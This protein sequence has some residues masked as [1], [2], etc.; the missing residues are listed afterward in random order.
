MGL[1]LTIT[2]PSAKPESLF[3]STDD[4]VYAASLPCQTQMTGT[5]QSL[6]YTTGQSS[7]PTDFQVFAFF[8]FQLFPVLSITKIGKKNG[9]PVKAR[10]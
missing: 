7:K 8:C 2:P 4:L 10:Q 9:E 1:T 5:S 3:G 6:P